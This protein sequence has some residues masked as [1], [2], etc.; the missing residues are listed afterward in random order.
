MNFGE[1]QF[2]PQQQVMKLEGAW[3]PQHPRYSLALLV[4]SQPSVSYKS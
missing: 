2:N 1:T 4:F 3:D